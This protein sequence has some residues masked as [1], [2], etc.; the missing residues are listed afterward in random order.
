MTIREAIDAIVS[1]GRSACHSERPYRCHAAGRGAAKESWVGQ[2]VARRIGG[3]E[4]P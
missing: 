2:T 1:Y 4:Q 3:M